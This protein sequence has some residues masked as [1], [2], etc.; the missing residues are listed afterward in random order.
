MVTSVWE[1]DHVQTCILGLQILVHG[2]YNLMLGLYTNNKQ[3]CERLSFKIHSMK[4]NEACFPF[5]SVSAIHQ[6]CSYGNTTTNRQQR[7]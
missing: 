3:I 1:K 2:L 5:S 7:C 4:H 6:K